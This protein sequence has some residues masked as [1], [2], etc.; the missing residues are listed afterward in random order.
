MSCGRANVTPSTAHVPTQLSP[1]SG[2]A[3]A[4][5]AAC[6]PGMPRTCARMLCQYAPHCAG[7]VNLPR[8][9]VIRTVNSP[10][11]RNPGAT[12]RK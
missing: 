3:C 8:G 11:T 12:S 9:G 7:E 4:K 6:T 2:S 10:S 1:V 5:L